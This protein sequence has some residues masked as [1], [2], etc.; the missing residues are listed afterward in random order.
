MIIDQKRHHHA[1]IEQMVDCVYLSTYVLYF[2]SLP[3]SYHL[4]YVILFWYQSLVNR[5]RIL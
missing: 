1:P 5:F 2:V 3:I 4:L